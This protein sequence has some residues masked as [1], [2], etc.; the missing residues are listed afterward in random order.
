MGPGR[1]SQ[2]LRGGLLDLLLVAVPAGSAVL[3]AGSG[4]A[5]PLALAAPRQRLTAR[6]DSCSCG[7]GQAG[8]GE[9]GFAFRAVQAAAGSPG[10][11]LGGGVRV[12]LP[13]TVGT[14]T[15]RQRADLG[16]VTLSSCTEGVPGRYRGACVGLALN[17][18]ARAAPPRGPDSWP[19]PSRWQEGH[20]G[21]GGG[22]SSEG[23]R[24]L[25]L[26]VQTG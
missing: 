26:S 10:L 19:P 25:E 12:W 24:E 1:R 13:T 11:E 2:G 16:T 4:A 14:G 9:E 20:R 22:G 17:A 18:G 6:C 23:Q 15:W 21:P 8:R 7:W 3:D 5:L